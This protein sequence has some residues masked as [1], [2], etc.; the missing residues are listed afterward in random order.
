MRLISIDEYNPKL[1]QLARPIFDKHRRILLG[2]GRTIH[3][4]YLER[5]VA[6]DIRYLFIEDAASYGITMEE[7]VDVPTWMEA[8]ETLKT[9]FE[10]V[11]EKK[12]L[13]IR[14]LQ[15]QVVLFVEEVA[16]RKALFLIPTSS[17]AEELREYAHAVNVSLLSLQLAKKLG[18]SQKPLK[19]LA[20]G[21]LLHDIGKAL[22]QE[23]EHHARSGFEYLRKVREVSI[24]SAHVAYQHHEAIDGSGEPR[25][26]A[27]KEIHEFAQICALANVYDNAI[28][29]DRLPPHEAME[30]IMTKSGTLFPSELISLFVQQVP[31][32]IPGTMVRLNNGR[33]AIVTK[34]VGN[35]QRPFVRYFDTE[36]EISLG[37]HHTLLITEVLDT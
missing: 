31:S 20:L 2:V 19:D 35:L 11:K 34:I 33:D 10:A 23:S 9:A 6:L 13:P 4:A 22:G 37:D 5:L 32:Y 24:V 27:E 26:L 12:E 3:P 29:K 15:K 14:D 18:V 21:C 28:S 17:L 25:G 1:M 30:Y 36:E 8:I 16:K 7:M